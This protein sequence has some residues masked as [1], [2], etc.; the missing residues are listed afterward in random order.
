MK[1]QEYFDRQKQIKLTDI[2]KLNLYHDFLSKTQKNKSL[3]KRYLN[4]SKSFTYSFLIFVLLTSIFGVYFQKNSIADFGNFGFMISHNDAINTVQANYIAKVVEFQW[5]YYIENE[6]NT[7]RSSNIASNDN[8]ILK[9][10]AKL[11]FNINLWTQAVVVGPAKI[12]LMQDPNNENSYTLTLKEGDYME[13]KTLDESL[14]QENIEI[15]LPDNSKIKNNSKKV[16]F[17]LSKIDNE[18]AIKNNWEM[19][20]VTKEDVNKT[21]NIENKQ[22]ISFRDND[23]VLI[24]DPQEFEQ[25]LQKM[26]I[27]QTFSV[28]TTLNNSWD[29]VSTWVIALVDE[30][31]KTL[32][33]IPSEI[34]YKE[35]SMSGAELLDLEEIST[36]VTN[37]QETPIVKSSTINTKDLPSEVDE[38][39][40]E[41]LAIDQKGLPSTAQTEVI[42]NVLNNS[43]IKKNM[44]NLTE[45]YLLW[46]NEEFEKQIAT[47]VW[48]FQKIENSFNIDFSKVS[49]DPSF[50]LNSIANN[51]VSFNEKLQ[52][53]FFLPNKYSYN[54]WVIQN[55]IKQLTNNYNYG[56]VNQE[57]V[58]SII[59]NL[60]SENIFQ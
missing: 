38:K 45:A 37:V 35:A 48:R 49:W 36:I 28:I 58:A 44:E 50:K 47:L 57:N 12:S 15:I 18:Y 9:K 51:S 21:Q 23:L 22:I 60:S 52:N 7:Y 4:F 13:I 5:D 27:S 46:D 17:Q 24:Q 16:D 19:L 42:S 55:R 20:V 25:A 3:T 59:M 32:N 43:F 1:I 8:I 6:G 54:I 40:I 30:I 34:N 10:W 53:S 26:Q 33:Q 31:D 14:V 11:V 2:E 41:E 39:I 29:I 56:E